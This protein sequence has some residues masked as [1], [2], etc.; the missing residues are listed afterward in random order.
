MSIGLIIDGHNLFLRSHYSGVRSGMETSEGVKSGTLYLT[1]KL[2]YYVMKDIKPNYVLWAFDHGR[3]QYRLSIRPEYKANRDSKSSNTYSNN[4]DEDY[5]Y[6]KEQF[7][8]LL[9]FLDTA[10]IPYLRENGMEADDIIASVSRAW[11]CPTVILS[12]DHDLLQLVSNKTTV[13]SNNSK[14]THMRVWDEEKVINEHNLPPKRLPEMWAFTGDSGDNIIGIKGI[15]PVKA[16]KL[17][18]SN[19]EDFSKALS[20]LSEEDQKRVKENYLLIDLSSD[21]YH[22]DKVLTQESCYVYSNSELSRKSK[23]D[24]TTFFN[25]WEFDSL[26]NSLISNTLY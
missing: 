17:L 16:K 26:S 23:Q 22:S 12:N 15:G 10:G 8:G 21:I 6:F 18:T 13:V 2:F 3:S 25:K 20:T 11:P 7:N 24:L 5:D 14:S 4:D 19:N 9:E 1:L